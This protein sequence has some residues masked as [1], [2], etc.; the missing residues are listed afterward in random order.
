M[1]I[2]RFYVSIPLDKLIDKEGNIYEMTCV[3][4]KEANIISATSIKDEIEESGEKV[5]SHVLT[6]VLNDEIKYSLEEK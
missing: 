4:I 3:A 2:R 5:V 1:N 6:Q